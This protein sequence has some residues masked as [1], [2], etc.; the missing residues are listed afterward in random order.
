M[1]PTL[2]LTIMQMPEFCNSRSEHIVEKEKK[3]D[4]SRQCRTREQTNQ[5]LALLL[6]KDISCFA[7]FSVSM[8]AF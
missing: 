3:S 4:F 5:S 2:P 1:N 8:K 7:N 6:L